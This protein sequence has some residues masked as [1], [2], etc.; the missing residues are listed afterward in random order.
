M[1][2]YK[3]VLNVLKKRIPTLKVGTNKVNGKFEFSVYEPD[4]PAQ[5]LELRSRDVNKL[6]VYLEG[7]LSDEKSLDMTVY[8]REGVITLQFI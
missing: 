5:L 2:T 3:D 6:E 8:S 7:V 4:Y 1:K